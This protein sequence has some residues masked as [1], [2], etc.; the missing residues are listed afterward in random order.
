MAIHRSAASSGIRRCGRGRA[1]HRGIA[2]A[3]IAVAVASSAPTLITLVQALVA[4]PARAATAD[5]LNRWEP[6]GDDLLFVAI[7][8]FA[9]VVVMVLRGWAA[10]LDG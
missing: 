7:A 6:R 4:D 1:V 8:V 5:R 9:A 10:V 2:V 3:G